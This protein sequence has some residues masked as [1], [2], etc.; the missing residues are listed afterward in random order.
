MSDCIFCK[1]VKGQVPCEKVYEDEQVLAFLDISPVS[2]GHTLVVPKIHY[3]DLVRTP[4]DVVCKCVDAISKLAP[5]IVSATGSEGFNI[6]LNNGKAAGQVVFHTHFHIIPRATND[7]L[8]NWAHQKYGQGES[9]KVQ[10]LI[11]HAMSQ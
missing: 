5:A 9:A 2:P 3:E 8:V 4:H 1:I 7:G 10:K 6:G 11:V